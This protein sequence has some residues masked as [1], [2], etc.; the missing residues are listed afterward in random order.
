MTD[1]VSML[2]THP[3]ARANAFRRLGRQLVYEQRVFWRNPPAAIF[4]FVLPLAFLVFIGI[5]NQHETVA[6]HGTIAA[7]TYYV[8]AVM[9]YGVMSTSYQNLA[10]VLIGRRQTGLLRRLRCTPAPAS[11]IVG[12]LI[13]G[14]LLTCVGI[15]VLIGVVG[16]VAFDVAPAHSLPGLVTWIVL[17]ATCFGALGMATSTLVNNTDAAPPLL[18][19]GFLTLLGASGVFTPLADH[20]HVAQA[21]QWL[22][23]APLVRGLVTAYLGPNAGAGSPFSL[24]PIA[25]V[26]AWTLVGAIATTR[27]FRWLP[28]V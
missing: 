13:A 16:R 22:P 23:A 4:T 20:S 5:A 3:Q 7:T 1:L 10:I 9:A 2:G 12:G 8:P 19:I 28:K 25:V 18:S 21:A 24:A 6:F 27:R 26:V 15:A 11:L 17:G 14:T